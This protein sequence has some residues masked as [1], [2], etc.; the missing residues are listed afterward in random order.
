M[1]IKLCKTKRNRYFQIIIN[2][3]TLFIIA[4]FIFEKCKATNKNTCY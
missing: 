1:G 3:Q 4:I 2:L